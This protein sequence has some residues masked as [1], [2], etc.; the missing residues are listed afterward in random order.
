MDGATDNI[1]KGTMA[2]L[3]TKE[4][5]VICKVCSSGFNQERNYA[6][7]HLQHLAL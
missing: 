1:G 6:M 2:N 5:V 7:K 4:D 3:K